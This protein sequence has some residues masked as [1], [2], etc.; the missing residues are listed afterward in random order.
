M[1]LVRR[2]AHYPLPLWGTRLQP[3]QLLKVDY[4]AMS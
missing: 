3:S 1:L 4:K 2:Y